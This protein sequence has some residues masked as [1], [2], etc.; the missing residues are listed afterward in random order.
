MIPIALP[1][2]RLVPPTQG[3][4]LNP[5]IDLVVGSLG[6]DPPPLRLAHFVSSLVLFKEVGVLPTTLGT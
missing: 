2:R 3:C 5:R 1:Q 6:N 4:S